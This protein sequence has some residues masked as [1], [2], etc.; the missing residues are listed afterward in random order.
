MSFD[1]WVYLPT[2]HTD[3]RRTLTDAG[4]MVHGVKELVG[5]QLCPT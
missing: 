5:E 3:T 4:G 1:T 2:R